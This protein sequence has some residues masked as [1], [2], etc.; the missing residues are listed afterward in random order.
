MINFQRNSWEGVSQLIKFNL[1]EDND[2]NKEGRNESEGQAVIK[3]YGLSW[4]RQN[5]A[6][7]VEEVGVS[8]GQEL[9][10]QLGQAGDNVIMLFCP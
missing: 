6:T 3:F 7:G 1:D 4:F 2:V 9:I 10:D 8:A 5:A